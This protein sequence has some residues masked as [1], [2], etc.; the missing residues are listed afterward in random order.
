MRR[1]LFLLM[2]ASSVGAAGIAHAQD[3]SPMLSYANPDRTT[4]ELV[5]QRGPCSDPWVTLAQTRVF[6]TATLAGCDIKRYN[7]GSWNSYNELIHAMGMTVPLTAVSINDFQ[8]NLYR[9]GQLFAVLVNS[10]YY[11][12]GND[13]ASLVGLDGST[14]RLA[15]LTALIG[16]DSAGATQVVLSERLISN[17]QIPMRPRAG[18]RLSGLTSFRTLKS[19]TRRR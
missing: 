11:L 2:A 19:S 3:Y 13:G 10:L 5:R 12:V 4:E 16:N 7:N 14:L 8:I 15:D 17:M 18:Y 1:I 6:G 9:S